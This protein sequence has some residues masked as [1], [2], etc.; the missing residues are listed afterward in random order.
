LG[1]HR[2][3][4]IDTATRRIKLITEQ[5]VGRARR[6]AKPVV[7]TSF[8]NPVGFSQGRTLQLRGG[9]GRLHHSLPFPP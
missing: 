2:V 9:K 8:Q 7:I 5:N 3:H 1:E 6:R 4:Q